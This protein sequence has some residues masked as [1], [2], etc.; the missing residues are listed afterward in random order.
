MGKIHQRNKFWSGSSQPFS[1]EPT[2]MVGWL[3]LTSKDLRFLTYSDPEVWQMI[4]VYVYV[5]VY[6]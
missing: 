6:M 5:Y 2:T 3:F 4:Y 1:N